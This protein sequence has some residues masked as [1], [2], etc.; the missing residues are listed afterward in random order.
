M[1]APR[2]INKEFSDLKRDP[3][4]GVTAGPKG[5][6]IFHWTATI[7][8]PDSSPYEGGLFTLDIRFPSDYPFQPPRFSFTTRIYHPNINSRGGICLDILKETWSPALTVAK[9]LLSI[10]SLLCDPNPD[11]PLVPEIATLYKTNREKY[12]T[13]ARE[14]TEKYAKK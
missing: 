5:E 12:N 13:H 7:K 10:T 8:G 2:R 14:Y 11:D 4:P 1:T 3:I 9:V 6:D